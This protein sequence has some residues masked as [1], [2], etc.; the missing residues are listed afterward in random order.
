MTAI[1]GPFPSFPSQLMSRIL[2]NIFRSEQT[3]EFFFFSGGGPRTSRRPA[4][5]WT[6]MW[7]AGEANVGAL[8]YRQNLHHGG[9]AQKK[10]LGSQ[11][12]PSIVAP[13]MSPQASGSISRTLCRIVC[14][15]DFSLATF[16]EEL[17]LGC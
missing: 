17:W 5:L 2:P 15:W 9:A 4:D 16:G 7:G 14:L 13:Q 12:P 1:V 11:V 8:P 3:K 10:T 6:R